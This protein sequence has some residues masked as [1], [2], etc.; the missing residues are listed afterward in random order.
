MMGKRKGKRKQ[1][2]MKEKRQGKKKKG[3]IRIVPN[4]FSLLVMRQ[5]PNYF[6]E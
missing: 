3:E 5:K 4:N 1:E 6:T 2:K